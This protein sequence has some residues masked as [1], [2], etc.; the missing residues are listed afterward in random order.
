[1]VRNLFLFPVPDLAFYVAGLSRVP[2]RWLLPSVFLGRG[3]GLVFMNTLGFLTAR[4]PP[5]W[6][7]A[8]W[9][10]VALAAL[11]IYRYQQK[12]RLYVLIALWKARQFGRRTHKRRRASRFAAKRRGSVG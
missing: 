11:V 4:L 5:E 9:L 8:K 12:I 1:M 3:V 2:L 6:V 10:M 7:L